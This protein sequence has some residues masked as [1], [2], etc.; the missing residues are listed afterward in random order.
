M[1]SSRAPVAP[2]GLVLALAA[3]GS[4]S[5]NTTPDAAVDAPPADAWASSCAPPAAITTVE[6]ADASF[7]NSCVHGLWFLQA[8]NGTT[9]PTAPGRPDNTTPVVP[10]SIAIDFDPLDPSSTFAVHVTGSGQENTGTTFAFA[11]LTASL[12]APS[13]TQI[14]TVDAT[15]FTG[16]QFYGIVNTGTTGAR[17]TVGDLFTDPA[18]GRCTTTPGQTTSCFDNPGAQLAVS[19]TW[20]KYQIPFTSLTQLGFGNPSPVGAAF[21]K[22]A[23]THLKWDIGIPSTGPTAAWELW[24]DDLSFY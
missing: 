2:A 8:L 3:C 5:S 16:I 12:N 18:G 4:V 13:A 6:T 17:L 9:T 14:G 1:R 23:I 20:M 21:P 11:Q 19:T 24:I 7:G 10:M 22:N 15:A